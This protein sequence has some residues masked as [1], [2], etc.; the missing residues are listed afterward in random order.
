[1][2]GGLSNIVEKALG[3]IA[4]AGSTAIRAVAG[5]GEKV[6]AQRSGVCGHPGE[7]F[8]LRHRSNWHP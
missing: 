4:K 5:H 2:R 1:M 6:T 7:R 3:S 8:H